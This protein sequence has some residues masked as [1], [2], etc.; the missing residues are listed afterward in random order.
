MTQSP[1]E[2]YDIGY[3]H[4]AGPRTPAEKWL[5]PRQPDIIGSRIKPEN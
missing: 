2:V 4:Y 1:G 5:D 3:Q